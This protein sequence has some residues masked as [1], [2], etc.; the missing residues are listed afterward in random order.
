MNLNFQELHQLS[1]FHRQSAETAAKQRL[2][3]DPTYRRWC[4]AKRVIWMSLLAGAFL[5][6]YLIAKLGEALALL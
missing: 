2:E 4:V 1:E 5:F 6:Y 3:D